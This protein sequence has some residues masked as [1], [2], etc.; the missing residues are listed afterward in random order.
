MIPVLRVFAITAGAAT[1]SAMFAAL[2]F[3]RYP[4]AVFPMVLFG[5]VGAIVGSVAAAAG[6]IVAVLRKR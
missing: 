5:S 6:E 2:L 1:V 3:Q 4:D